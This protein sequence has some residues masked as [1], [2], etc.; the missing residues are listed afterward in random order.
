ME[1]GWLWT[2]GMRWATH[3]IGLL[4]PGETLVE[5]DPGL[6]TGAQRTAARCVACSL[7]LVNYED[8]G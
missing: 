5:R 2:R 6:V 4:D 3:R 7:V 1:S 8:R